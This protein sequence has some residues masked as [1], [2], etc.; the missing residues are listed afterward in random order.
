MFS[1]PWDGW[2]RMEFDGFLTK[3]HTGKISNPVDAR[4]EFCDITIREVCD[5]MSCHFSAWWIHIFFQRYSHFEGGPMLAR[6]NR[7]WPMEFDCRSR[8]STRWSRQ[9][10]FFFTHRQVASRPDWLTDWSS[11]LSFVFRAV[12]ITGKEA[13]TISVC[14]SK[15][16]GLSL[17]C[18]TSQHRASRQI[19][20]SVA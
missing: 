7:I 8:Q 5:K 17:I 2:T 16:V 6:L 10:R 14:Q 4:D 13:G 9:F 18:E 11:S 1:H 20:L 19:S 12:Y 15:T 3:R